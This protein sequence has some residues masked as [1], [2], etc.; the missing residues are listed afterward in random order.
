[1]DS[2]H[3]EIPSES[4]SQKRTNAGGA[5][6]PDHLMFIEPIYFVRKF[7]FH[8]IKYYRLAVWSERVVKAEKWK[9]QQNIFDAYDLAIV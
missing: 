1:M 3:P 9:K 7:S 4:G 5:G 2:V 6:A 8:K